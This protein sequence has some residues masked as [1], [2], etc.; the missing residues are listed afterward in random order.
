MQIGGFSWFWGNCGKGIFLVGL[1]D[2]LAEKKSPARHYCQPA[3][4]YE[5]LHQFILVR[6]CRVRLPLRG[7]HAFF[8]VLIGADSA[9]LSLVFNG[10]GCSE[11]A[12]ESG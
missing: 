12:Q 1:A 9:R 3:T 5:I 4:A 11:R 6:S 10:L 2:S 7:L 8:V